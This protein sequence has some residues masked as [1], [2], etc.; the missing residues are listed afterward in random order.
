MGRYLLSQAS[1]CTEA[2]LSCSLGTANSA[3]RADATA[4]V[5]VLSLLSLGNVLVILGLHLGEMLL[6]VYKYT[7]VPNSFFFF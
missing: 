1:L 7:Y 5:T 2:V 3:S 4:K 6:D